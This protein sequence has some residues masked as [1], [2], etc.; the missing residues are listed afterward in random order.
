MKIEMKGINKSFGQNQVLKDAGFVLDDG[1]VHALMGEN[2]AGKSTLMKILTGVYTRDGGT[3]IVDGKEVTYKS[4]Q[5][6]ERAGIVFIQQ[7][8][9]VL[10]DLTVEENL[11]LGKE[12]KKGFGICDRKAMRQRPRKPKRLGVS[13]PTDKVMSELSVG[14]QQ[15]IEICKD[16]DGWTQKSSSWMNPRQPLPRARQRCCLRSC[17]PCEKRECPSSIYPTAWRKSLSFATAFP[18]S[19]TAHT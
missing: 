11:F 2:G 19:G 8:L 18:F 9:N 4:P 1:E 5:E 17:S 12:I 3:V 6:A 13:I 10:F 14:Q 16:P 7:E 15:M